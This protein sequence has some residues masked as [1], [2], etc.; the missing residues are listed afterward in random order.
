MARF[1]RYCGA[2]ISDQAAFCKKCGAKLVPASAGS[3][4]AGGQVAGTGHTAAPQSP[5]TRHPSYQPGRPS[6]PP[7]AGN[8]P[9]QQS[10]QPYHPQRPQPQQPYH[11]QWPQPQQPQLQSPQPRRSSFKPVIAAL[12][13]AALF[14]CFVYPGFVRKT[15]SGGGNG[16]AGNGPGWFLGGGKTPG[17]GASTHGPAAHGGA[18]EPAGPPMIQGHSRAFSIEPLPG[19]KISAEE[20]ALDSDREFKVTALPEEELLALSEEMEAAG[21]YVLSA[22]HLDAGLAPDEYL[23]GYF[24]VE[25]DL[26][27]YGIPEELW[28]QVRISRID[29]NGKRFVYNTDFD[30]KTARIRSRQ[31]SV[32]VTSI[33]SVILAGIAGK[34]VYDEVGKDTAYYSGL[35]M[36][37]H[38]LPHFEVYFAAEDLITHKAPGAF[39]LRAR[40]LE[41]L[42]ADI[43]KRVLESSPDSGNGAG[44]GAGNGAFTGPTNL[45]ESLEEKVA[46]YQKALLSDPA[47]LAKKKE[48]EDAYP[49][50]LKRIFDYLEKAYDYMSGPEQKRRAPSYKMKIYL[51]L[52]IDGGEANTHKVLFDNPAMSVAFGQIYESLSSGPVTSGRFREDRLEALLIS[53]SHEMTHACQYEYYTSGISELISASLKLVEATACVTEVEALKYFIGRGDLPALANQSMEELYAVGPASSGALTNRDYPVWYAM[54]LNEP[55]PQTGGSDIGYALAYFLDYLNEEHEKPRKTADI[56]SI[57]SAGMTFSKAMMEAYD[58]EAD[59]FQFDFIDFMQKSRD[60]GITHKDIMNGALSG[61][62]DYYGQY[63]FSRAGNK[64]LYQEARGSFDGPSWRYNDAFMKMHRFSLS[65]S[66]AADGKKALLVL[67]DPEN[68]ADGDRTAA[69]QDATHGLFELRFANSGNPLPPE[70]KYVLDEVRNILWIE[71]MRQQD[72][73][74]SEIM[75]LADGWLASRVAFD[76]IA[77]T[78]PDYPEIF[79]EQPAPGQ[80]V[81]RLPKDKN[82]FYTNS[83]VKKQMQEFGMCVRKP[84]EKD[85]KRMQFFP[86]EQ[87]GTDVVLQKKDVNIDLN[88]PYGM[89]ACAYF[90][91]NDKYYFGPES[92]E[93]KDLYG[94]YDVE[95]TVKEYS[96]VLDSIV[97]QTMPNRKEFSDYKNTYQDISGEMIGKPRKAT[98]TV[99]NNGTVVS[100]DVIAGGTLSL[101]PDPGDLSSLGGSQH[102]TEIL[103]ILTYGDPATGAPAPVD[104]SS[105][106]AAPGPLSYTF[107]GVI[108]ADQKPV[109]LNSGGKNAKGRTSIKVTLAYDAGNNYG[110]T[111]LDLQHVQKLSG[112]LDLEF[113]QDD[114]G[115]WSVKGESKFGY[116]KNEAPE[117]AAL[118]LKFWYVLEGE[119][120]D[121]SGLAATPQATDVHGNPIPEGYE[122]A[123]PLPQ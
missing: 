72:Y 69:M 122:E 91:L 35:T 55:A 53:I 78:P 28:D 43:L 31:N 113:I 27:E 94:T 120:S 109:R 17:N 45:K 110:N 64:L 62:Q 67:P 41:D 119:K 24:D 25:L 61:S 2:E 48:M 5:Q 40:E 107:K 99:I 86:A 49:E 57:Y 117:L 75:G 34:Y 42:K 10:Q 103:A 84:G 123:P 90:K 14:V 87:V 65:A 82:P 115:A 29:D 50:E 37:T 51:Q 30:G 9:R 63:S 73:Y 106:T 19:V 21:E 66:P 83:Y 22:V 20:N 92:E 97:L 13:A 74:L 88:D 81:F 39:L 98:L 71:E 11:S 12:L 105:L 60:E 32:L 93:V 59:I 85:E 56:M 111:A 101:S 7:G 4:P 26:S 95:V 77:V 47:Y 112:P 58:L 89:V 16:G 23:P 70:D 121:S 52:S 44:S 33:L 3:P 46:A 38:S 80:V 118:K 8:Q 15:L 18:R 76:A 96:S 114:S 108:T 6:V 1:C 100:N 104:A 116:G 36:L 79:L 102:G 68:D 54:P